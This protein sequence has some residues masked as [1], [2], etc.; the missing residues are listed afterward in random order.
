MNERDFLIE[1]SIQEFKQIE[2]EN[3][4]LIEIA[5][6]MKA[7][8]DEKI[9]Y[10][11]EK[12]QLAEEYLLTHIE[13]QVD[14]KEMKETKTEFNIKFPSAKVSIS[15]DK[16]VLLKPDINNCPDEYI[17]VKTEVDW[18]NYKK[19][20]SI[21]GNNVIDKTTGEIKDVE[22]KIVKGGEVKIK[23]DG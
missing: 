5:E 17:K 16:T 15:K 2:A 11:A 6:A 1:K 9:Q 20:L 23:I 19:N 18:I 21:V 4:R 10:Y 8:Y 22:T 12:I 13:S 3:K 7:E 14:I